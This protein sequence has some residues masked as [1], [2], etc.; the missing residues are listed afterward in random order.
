MNKKIVTLTTSLTLVF[1]SF[2]SAQD[3]QDV[4]LLQ[5]LLAQEAPLSQAQ[6]L[7]PGDRLDN[8]IT[9]ITNSIEL[10]GDTRVSMIADPIIGGLEQYVINKVSAMKIADPFNLQTDFTHATSV[11]AGNFVYT[12]ENKNNRPF[13]AQL[14]VY[15]NSLNNPPVNDESPIIVEAG[16]Q[17]NTIRPITG[18]NEFFRFTITDTLDILVPENS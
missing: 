1:S 5:T 3:N 4:L 2:A 16:Q 14:Q 7:L 10:S 18:Q 17:K 12:I 8:A 15:T 11:E 9:A 6:I 13:R